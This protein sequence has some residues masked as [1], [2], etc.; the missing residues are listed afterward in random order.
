MGVRRGGYLD[1]PVRGSAAAPV[2]QFAFVAYDADIWLQIVQVVFIQ[3]YSEGGGID[4]TG[5]MPCVD[6]VPDDFGKIAKPA[7]GESLS[8][9]PPYTSVR[10]SAPPSGPQAG[11]ICHLSYRSFL[12][13]MSWV[14]PR[15]LFD[16]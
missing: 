12:V 6:V 13:L 14:I 3:K 10:Q 4:F 16:F 11:S 1:Y 9:E 15:F 2:I 5:A 7:S 8:V